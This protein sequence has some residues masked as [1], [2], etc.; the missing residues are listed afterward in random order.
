[1]AFEV[2]SVAS[3]S[4]SSFTSAEIGTPQLG[5]WELLDIA[6][7]QQAEAIDRLWLLQT[8]PTYLLFANQSQYAVS[9]GRHDLA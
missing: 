4:W 2:Q 7:A 3:Q 6:K 5:F 8:D 9:D 1:M